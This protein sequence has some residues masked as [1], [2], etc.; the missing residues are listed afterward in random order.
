VRSSGGVPIRYKVSRGWRAIRAAEIV[1][2]CPSAV[3]LDAA[4]AGRLQSCRA[5]IAHIA[6]S[7]LVVRRGIIGS[8]L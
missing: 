6:K 4:K 1:S 2:F 5:K 7:Y 8:D 3:V